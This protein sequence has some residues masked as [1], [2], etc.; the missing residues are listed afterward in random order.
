MSL[1][2]QTHLESRPAV[3]GCSLTD[4][5]LPVAG[6]AHLEIPLSLISLTLFRNCRD[7]AAHL[8]QLSVWT[9]LILQR[10]QAHWCYYVSGYFGWLGSV[11]LPFS[12]ILVNALMDLDMS[13]PPFA[14]LGDGRG[15]FS[16]PGS[17]PDD[18]R[19]NLSSSGA[20]CR[21]RRDDFS[22]SGPTGAAFVM[23]V[24]WLKDKF[25]PGSANSDRSRRL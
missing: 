20:E 1:A 10:S 2:T 6:M 14:K 13:Q 12:A 16:S 4:G 11:V 5:I 3:F 18:R 21:G 9:V 15:D 19:G 22:P 23:S 17:R 24:W 7:D 8:V 25:N